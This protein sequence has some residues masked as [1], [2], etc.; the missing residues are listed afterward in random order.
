[1]FLCEFVHALYLAKLTS[2]TKCEYKF[3]YILPR[4]THKGKFNLCLMVTYPHAYSSKKE[5]PPKA[6]ILILT[7]LSINTKEHYCDTGAAAF[8]F[9]EALTSWSSAGAALSEDTGADADRLESETL[10]KSAGAFCVGAFWTG[11]GL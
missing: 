4:A 7:N 1:M 8:V 6:A 11:E 5:K 2:L 3:R 10:S 9:A